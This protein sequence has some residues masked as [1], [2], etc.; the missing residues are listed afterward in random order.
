M[1]KFLHSIFGQVLLALI[2]GIAVGLLWPDFAQQLKPLGDGF[3]KM[4]I[5]Y[6]VFCVVVH[7][8]ASWEGDIDKT[9]AKAVLDNPA[10]LH[11]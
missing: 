3:I 7:G 5:P 4:L 8:I 2:I 11:S 1:A 6:I 10:A 9:K